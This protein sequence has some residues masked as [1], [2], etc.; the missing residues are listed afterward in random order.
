MGNERQ[1]ALRMGLIGPHGES[2]SIGVTLADDVASDL[3]RISPPDT[4]LASFGIGSTFD[5]VVAVLRKKQFRK[6]L[7]QQE[8]S[9]LGALLAERMEDAEGWHDA[10][11][12]ESAR[13]Q[14]GLPPEGDITP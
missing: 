2:V 9:R 4:A 5:Q 7:F 13:K 8:A 10:S 12:I 1:G 14:L 3:Y 11:R 6:D